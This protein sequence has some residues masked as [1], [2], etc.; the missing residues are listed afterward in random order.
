MRVS[1]FEINSIIDGF[2]SLS[3]WK[4]PNMSPESKD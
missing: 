1:G 4:H 2:S 3:P